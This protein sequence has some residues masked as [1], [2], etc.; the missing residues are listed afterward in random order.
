MTIFDQYNP[1]G[2]K[3][4]PW[5]GFPPK[6]SSVKLVMRRIRDQAMEPGRCTG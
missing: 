5:T 1:G 4:G 6:A 2:D 3:S